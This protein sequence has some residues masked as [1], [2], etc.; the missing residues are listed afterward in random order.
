[1]EEI[2]KIIVNEINRRCSKCKT[3]Y[4]IY[5]SRGKVR[6]HIIPTNFHK[7]S[8]PDCGHTENLIGVKF[9]KWTRIKTNSIRNL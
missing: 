3:G 4:L 9:P 2:R 7:C 1:M 8:N 6:F 5:D